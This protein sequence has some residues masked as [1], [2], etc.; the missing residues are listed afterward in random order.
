MR[1]DET[2]ALAFREDLHAGFDSG[3]RDK[4]WIFACCQETIPQMDL[5]QPVVA[6]QLP[7]IIN[8]AGYWKNESSPSDD[9]WWKPTISMAISQQW[10]I[11]LSLVALRPSL[12][13]IADDGCYLLPSGSC[14]SAT[15]ILRKLTAWHIDKSAGSFEIL[16]M[17]Q[18]MQVQGGSQTRPAWAASLSLPLG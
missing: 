17:P 13:T 16:L 6:Q 5:D 10:D 8:H 12:P 14:S 18:W 2:R 15:K 4:G 9:Q 1:L 11:I 7:R 3:W